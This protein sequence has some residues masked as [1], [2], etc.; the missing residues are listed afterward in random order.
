MIL[1]E[2]PR[3]RFQNLGKERIVGALSAGGQIPNREVFDHQDKPWEAQAIMPRRVT[4]VARS[5]A[6]R[7]RTGRGS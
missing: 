1:P 3:L 4:A 7:S 6:H 5:A 2:H